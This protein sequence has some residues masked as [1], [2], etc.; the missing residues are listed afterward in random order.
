[1]DGTGA[2]RKH[3][4]VA[5]MA[6]GPWEGLRIADGCPFLHGALPGLGVLLV[7]H[8]VVVILRSK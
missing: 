1:M 8:N 5:V 4:S 6:C 3:G 2:G 7:H